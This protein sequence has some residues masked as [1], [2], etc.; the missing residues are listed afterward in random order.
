MVPAIPRCEPPWGGTRQP[1]RSCFTP[2]AAYRSSRTGY[3]CLRGDSCHWHR[4][5]AGG[6]GEAIHGTQA[7]AVAEQFRT[8]ADI[9]L[10]VLNLRDMRRPVRAFSVVTH[11]TSPPP[12]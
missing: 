3:G 8:R 4:H 7:A 11:A 10:G 12:R 2:S 1:V 9:H 6:A 5:G